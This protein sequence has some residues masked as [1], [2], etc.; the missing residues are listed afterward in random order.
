[1][2]RL[3]LISRRFL[4]GL[5]ATLKLNEKKCLLTQ[6]VRTQPQSHRDKSCPAPK[7]RLSQD[8]TFQARQFFRL[9]QKPAKVVLM[10][11]HSSSRV[12]YGLIFQAHILTENRPA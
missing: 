8:I 1:M 6:V 4:V 2:R 12:G 10:N 9:G 11:E 7:P 3:L 5:S